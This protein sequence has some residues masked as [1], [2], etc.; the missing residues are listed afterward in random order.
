MSSK[1]T[2]AKNIIAVAAWVL[3]AGAVFLCAGCKEKADRTGQQNEFEISKEYQRG[4]LTVYVR[5]E[6]STITIAET[7]LLQLEAAI[8]PGF[9]VK[10]PEM[11]EVVENFGILD[12]HNPGDRL[13]ENNNI[14]RTY[15][16]RLEPFLSGT[17]AIPA[18]TFEFYD[19][20]S[21]QTEKY[22]LTTEPVDIEVTSLLGEQRGELVIADIEDVVEI[23]RQKSY[24]W[25]WTLAGVVGA[26]A[27]VTGFVYARR[28]RSRQI[29]RILKPAH[30]IAYER[31]RRLVKAELIK[32]GK[33]K[34]FYQQ[35]TDILRHYIEHRFNLRAPEQTTEE[36]L[37][38]LAGADVLADAD[39]KDLADFLNHC[40]LVKF[41][42]HRPATEQIQKTFD[43]VKN[44]IEKT[45][46]DDKQIDV[47][48]ADTEQL[49]GAG[50]V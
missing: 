34:Q 37:T 21:P 11:N 47:T 14:V 33:I 28:R 1:T 36:F 22:E 27:G 20:N 4:P 7:I 32:A 25:I 19:V 50:A 3:A 12:W 42:R 46:S 40:D 10:M 31:L 13:D 5:A 48:N 8:E 35:I 43:L 16:Y 24:W 38:E 6:K 30:E 29:I 26:A 2:R 17:F 18:L 41:A 49:I 9:E 39:K 44:F 45:K 23:P 15:R